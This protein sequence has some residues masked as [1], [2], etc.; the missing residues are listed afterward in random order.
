[1]RN[2]SSQPIILAYKATSDGATDNLGNRYYWGTAGTYDMSVTGIGKVEGRNAD[3]Q[4]VLAPGESRT[5]TFSLG[6]P[7]R[8]RPRARDVVD[9]GPDARAA[10]DLAEQSGSRRSR[11]RGELQDLSPGGADAG[12]AAAQKL[13][14]A[15]KSK[16][17]SPDH[18]VIPHERAIASECRDLLS[19]QLS[20]TMFSYR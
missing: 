6:A 16:L 11:I 17:G 8:Q 4:F 19:C 2:V 15:V 10:R 9:A 12:N 13:F 20:P 1:V 14:N 7:G 3:P 5:A 18:L